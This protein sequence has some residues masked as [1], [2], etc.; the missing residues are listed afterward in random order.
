MLNYPSL[1]VDNFYKDPDAVVEFAR[2]CKYATSETGRW[3]GQ[4]T[5]GLNHIDADFFH[6]FVVKVLSL[7]YDFNHHQA[8][9]TVQSSFQLISAY[10]PDPLSLKNRGWIHQD[11][12]TLLAGIIFLNPTTPL[13]NGTSLYQ[14]NSKFDQDFLN[15]TL[16]T[17]ENLYLGQ[18]SEDYDEVFSKHFDM[19][20]H[21]VTYKNVFNRAIVFDGQQYHAADSFFTTGESRLTQV[22]FV[23]K[24]S[25][26]APTPG[27]KIETFMF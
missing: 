1:C 26:T 18:C 22:F 11:D 5:T 10:D 16:K 20:D 13:S 27:E 8:S 7:F 2:S 9:Y 15:S 12:Q 25:I 23:E 3:P 21:T 17:K 24:L 4:R 14:P 6:D 19:F